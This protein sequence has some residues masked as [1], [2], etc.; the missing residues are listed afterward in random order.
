MSKKVM[1]LVTILVM[2]YSSICFANNGKLL[3]CEE[4]IAEKTIDCILGQGEYTVLAQ[5][6]T[7]SLA[8]KL[9]SLKFKE[10]KTTVNEQVGVLSNNKLVIL[11]KFAQA[12]RVIYLADGS[13]IK[14]VE[15][16]FVFDTTGKVPLLNEI[17]IRPMELKPVTK[18]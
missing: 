13:K 2:C 10:L 7:F 14:N 11:Q 12:D 8:K 17:T 6:F 15:I 1:L 3:T 16:S 9:T 4:K 5:N 18:K